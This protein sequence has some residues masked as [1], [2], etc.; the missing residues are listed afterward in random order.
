M[1]GLEGDEAAA[2]A[3]V[4]GEGRTEVL[5]EPFDRVLRRRLAQLDGLFSWMVSDEDR[6]LVRLCEVAH[7]ALRHSRGELDQLPV[8]P[9]TAARRA[10]L[11]RKV[12][13]KGARVALVGDDDL[14]AVAAAA[15]GL[16]PTVLDVDSDLI[17]L[18][19]IIA[20]RLG[21]D[22][23]LREVDL[24][25]PLPEDLLG[26]FDAF[27]TDPENSRECV[28]LFLSRGVSLLRPEGFGLVAGAEEWRELIDEASAQ[29]SLRREGLMC[30]FANYRSVTFQLASY[31]SDLHGFRVPP[32][33]EPLVA[34]DETYVGH[35][36]P[37]GLAGEAHLIATARK[38]VPANL[39]GQG[40]IELAAA[41]VDGGS[42]NPRVEDKSPF[43]VRLISAEGDAG[44]L[45]ITVHADGS[46]VDFD[47]S[48]SP[49]SDELVRSVARQLEERLGAGSLELKTLRRLE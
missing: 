24:R 43:P 36:F 31:R 48:P 29:M 33:V 7:S 4:L 37:F 41:I 22:I 20:P 40:L 23:S 11:L 46:T 28:C 49:A 5:E 16:A 21:L 39:T 9:E 27:C 8:L 6:W 19:R 15:V 30:R 44:R 12:V 42:G 38:C 18:Y 10:L 1:R 32:D 26:S 35:L 47:L 34:V 17:E 45:Q 14:L 13:G 2:Q 3:S 25:E